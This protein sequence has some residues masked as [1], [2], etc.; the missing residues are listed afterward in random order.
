[1]DS[2]RS[3]QNNG[4]KATESVREGEQ[5]RNSLMAREHIP[6]EKCMLLRTTLVL[7]ANSGK[8]LVVNVLVD[9]GSTQTHLNAILVAELDLEGLIQKTK[10]V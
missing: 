8:I 7:V 5:L 4:E 1:M 9:D 3:K 6:K 10:V 2:S